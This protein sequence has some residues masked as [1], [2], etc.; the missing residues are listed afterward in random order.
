M[1]TLAN[2]DQ[3]SKFL[4]Q[5]ICKK[6]LYVH[7]AKILTYLQYVATLRSYLVKVEN[8]KIYQL[9][10]LNVTINMFN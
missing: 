6:I 4:H 2:V 7:I 1:I 5:K 9:F 10:M 3:F 8:P